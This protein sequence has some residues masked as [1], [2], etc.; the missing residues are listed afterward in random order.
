MS[1]FHRIVSAVLLVTG[2]LVTQSAG[3]VPRDKKAEFYRARALKPIDRELVTRG[4]KGDFTTWYVIGVG[5]FAERHTPGMSAYA[6][7]GH[8]KIEQG[9]KA[10]GEFVVDFMLA[11][12]SDAERAILELRRNNP[13][14]FERLA[15]NR[16]WRYRAFATEQEAHYFRD[17][18]L[19]KKQ[20]TSAAD[21]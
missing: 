12:L 3:Q 8:L 21:K 9:R 16:M 7:D 6:L 19:P 17:S 11:P 4:S 13:Q 18:L 2:F 10:A 20:T 1:M 15:S 5:N 14:Q